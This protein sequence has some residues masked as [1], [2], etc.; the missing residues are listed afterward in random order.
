MKRH[1]EKIH[2]GKGLPVHQKLKRGPQRKVRMETVEFSSD[3]ELGV[4]MVEGQFQILKSGARVFT[5]SRPLKSY[6]SSS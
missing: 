2:P 4:K 6:S 3:E 5:V 1:V